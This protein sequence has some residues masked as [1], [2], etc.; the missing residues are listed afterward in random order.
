VI[1]VE[2]IDLI[3]RRIRRRSHDEDRLPDQA[4]V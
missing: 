1:V 4:D 2:V 3:Y